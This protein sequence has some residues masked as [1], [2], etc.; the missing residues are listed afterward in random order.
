MRRRSRCSSAGAVFVS[1]LQQVSRCLLP[2]WLP[3]RGSD[4]FRLGV[5]EE[6]HTAAPASL[7]PYGGTDAV[8]ARLHPEVGAVT[9]EVSDGVLELVTPVCE[10]TA[11]AIEIL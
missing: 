5:E 3:F 9:G 1:P 8:L 6:L 10:H 2:T 7:R 11:Q 4:H